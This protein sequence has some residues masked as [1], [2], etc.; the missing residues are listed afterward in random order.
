MSVAE[1]NSTPEGLNALNDWLLTRSFCDE[2]GFSPSQTDTVVF[3]KLTAGNLEEFPNVARWYR[4]IASYGVDI[5]SFPG[6]APEPEDGH[7][8]AEVATSPKVKRGADEYDDFSVDRRE[9]QA[10]D[11]YDDFSVSREREAEDSDE[12]SDDSD[13]GGGVKVDLVALD[14]ARKKKQKV[15]E[16]KQKEDEDKRKEAEA[17]KMA[18]AQS[19]I[20]FEV[21]PLEINPDPDATEADKANLVAKVKGIEMDGLRWGKDV[22]FVDVAKRFHIWKM[23][24][25]ATVVDV[26]VSVDLLEEK[27]QAL[28]GG[29]LVGSTEIASFNKL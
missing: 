17:E 20:V 27:I 10:E 9:P 13:F 21:K 5:E 11:E 12:S 15:H 14:K 29:T 19:I 25:Q 7:V 26:K 18:K 1:F 24:I 2:D 22:S 23:L 4:N 6:E 28:D 16:D 8:I 3:K